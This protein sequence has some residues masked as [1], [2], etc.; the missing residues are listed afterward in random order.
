[1]I[2]KIELVKLNSRLKKVP[3]ITLHTRFLSLSLWGRDLRKSFIHFHYI[4]WDI[5]FISSTYF[6]QSLLFHNCK[7]FRMNIMSLELFYGKKSVLQSD[8]FSNITKTEL[9]RRCF[10]S[11]LV[12]FDSWHGIWILD[13]KDKRRPCVSNS[14]PCIIRFSMWHFS[15]IL[16]FHCSQY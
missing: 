7:L 13:L 12:S 9:I 11:W 10:V 15:Y 3:V 4:H 5:L 6:T 1:M 16:F 8:Y 2:S 14:I